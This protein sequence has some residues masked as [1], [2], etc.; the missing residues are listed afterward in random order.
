M[1]RLALVPFDHHYLDLSWGWLADPEIKA[2]TMTPDFDRADQ[3]RFFDG[4]ADRSDYTIW[5]V[6]LDGA[7]P[8]GAD[9]LKRIDG[10]RAEYWGYIGD[11]DAWG[12]GLG[13]LMLAAIEAKAV[14]MGISRLYLRVAS[15]NVRAVSLYARAGYTADD[16]H[17]GMLTMTKAL[18]A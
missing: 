7:R 15:D 17:A 4:L 10:N 9:G 1:P 2:L 8:I 16:P 5:G 14:A 3:Q 18:G 12:Q 11:K 13:K 6:E